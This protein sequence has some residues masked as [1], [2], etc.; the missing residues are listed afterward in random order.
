MPHPGKSKALHNRLNAIGQFNGNKKK[1][2]VMEQKIEEQIAVISNLQVNIAENDKLID[3][4]NHIL[5]RQTEKL[6][7]Y[8][9]KLKIYNQNVLFLIKKLNIN[10]LFDFQNVLKE[11]GCITQLVKVL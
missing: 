6:S 4:K 9:A 5:S 10:T 7:S 1:I 8:L 3:A 2:S 11:K